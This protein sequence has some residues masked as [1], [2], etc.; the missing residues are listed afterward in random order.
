MPEII[1]D[2]Y[3]LIASIQSYLMQIV[4]TLAVGAL[5][6]SEHIKYFICIQICKFRL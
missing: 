4:I 2:I 6:F 1:V 3:C 5:S